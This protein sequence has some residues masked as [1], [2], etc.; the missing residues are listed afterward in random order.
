[1]FQRSALLWWLAAI[2]LS[3]LP[4][5]LFA[6]GGGTFETYICTGSPSAPPA[7]AYALINRV[8]G[9]AGSGGTGASEVTVAL[10]CF[11]ASAAVALLIPAA[12]SVLAVLARR[13]APYRRRALARCGAVTALVPPLLLALS[14]NSL[15]DECQSGGTLSASV[16]LYGATAALLLTASVSGENPW[17]AVAAH[18]LLPVLAVL[19][20]ALPSVVSHVEGYQLWIGTLIPRGNVLSL[21]VLKSA[22]LPWMVL[23]LV[24][25]LVGIGVMTVAV[26]L[27]VAV[28][29]RWLRLTV[30]GMLLLLAVAGVAAVIP[31]PPEA[32]FGGYTPAEV[33][34]DSQ[35]DFYMGAMEGSLRL[36]P[37]DSMYLSDTV[38][39]L[40]SAAF[41]AAAVLLIAYDRRT[42]SRSR[43]PSAHG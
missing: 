26:L 11:W 3:L 31:V 22:I 25:M 37:S 16:L 35:P 33:S 20:T 6:L 34:A 43:T 32:A 39:L 24:D 10:V 40:F 7:P 23:M 17:R 12:L 1:M 41:T 19:V 36:I 15:P 38:P 5:A 18:P 30:T 2:P 29:A 42:R 27:A 4:H 13:A 14:W 9:I 8:D 21:V 28:P